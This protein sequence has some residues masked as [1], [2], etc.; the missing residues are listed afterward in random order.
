MILNL[1]EP[2]VIEFN[3]VYENLCGKIESSTMCANAFQA[4]Q[5]VLVNHFIALS[6]FVSLKQS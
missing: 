6:V 3:K 2:I 1:S 4:Q 5:K